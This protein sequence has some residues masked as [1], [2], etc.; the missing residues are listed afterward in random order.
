MIFLLAKQR[1]LH[2][3]S[4][5]GR[6]IPVDLREPDGNVAVFEST[7]AIPVGVFVEWAN[8]GDFESGQVFNCRPV[9]RDQPGLL[10]ISVEFKGDLDY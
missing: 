8:A 4:E 2:V 7:E 10:E 9:R 5:S 1:T 3:F 6:S